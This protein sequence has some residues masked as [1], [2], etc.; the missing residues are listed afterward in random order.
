MKKL[1]L[2]LGTLGGTAIWYVFSNKSLRRELAKAKGPEEAAAL[3]VKHLSR[4]G[5][6]ISKEVHEFIQSEE[7][8]K[9]YM[10]LKDF[11]GDTY[12]RAKDEAGNLLEKGTKSAT[13]GA[14]KAKDT[15]MQLWKKKRTK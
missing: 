3:V 11:A 12:D 5:K 15:M 14:A 8:Q 7:F 2:L 10:K 4:D 9:N 1:S 13:E 6:K